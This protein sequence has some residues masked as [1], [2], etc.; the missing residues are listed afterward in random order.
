MKKQIQEHQVIFMMRR[1][2][3]KKK[4]EIIKLNMLREGRILYGTGRFSGAKEVAEM[5]RPLVEYSDR[6]MIVAMSVDA[7]I[8]PIALGIVAVGG[9]CSCS[10]DARDLFKHA[11]LA[12][13]IRIICFHY[14]P[15]G[16]PK[17]NRSDSII[18]ARMKAAGELF[19]I[20]LLDHIIIGADG[21]Y[22]SFREKKIAPFETGEFTA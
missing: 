17:P 14:H 19:G 15:S 9:V 4:V 3:H 18:T 1:P 8:S 10:I 13:A 20:E 16:E 12:N 5:V 6:E 11:I 2:E 22:V 7:E 21:K